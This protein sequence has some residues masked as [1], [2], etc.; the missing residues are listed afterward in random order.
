MAASGLLIS[1]PLPAGAVYDGQSVPGSP[2]VL[3]ILS[4]KESRQSFCSASLISERVVVT[5]AHCVIAS[6]SETRELRFSI[7]ETYVSQP[8]ADVR[9][10]ALDSRVRVLRVVT[11]D[12][13]VN[14]WKPEIGDVRTQVHDIAFMFLAQPLV[15]GYTAQVAT[16]QEVDAATAA[17]QSVTQFGYGLQQMGSQ[18]HTPWMTRM[19][20][21]GIWPSQLGPKSRY[22]M[23]QEGPSALCPGDSGGPWYIDVGGSLKLAAVTV[24]AGG[25]R[26][27]PPYNSMA[28]ATR[29]H[30][31]LDLLDRE[32]ARFLLDEARLQE[33]E[34]L[35]AT[36]LERA[37]SSGTF[38]SPG[39][40]HARGIGV[41]VQIRRV[42]GVWER[43]TGISGWLP[44]G[45]GC[46]SSHPVVPWAV[47]DAAAGSWLRWRYWSSSWETFSPTFQ[48]IL[49][50]TKP[51][52]A[53][54]E[55]SG[56]KV[57]I[58]CT[59]GK[60]TKR[61]TGIAPKCPSGYKRR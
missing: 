47:I 1:M 51:T 35:R 9:V 53:V 40:C 19:P 20:L 34:R 3:T 6:D 37:R 58:V 25:C 13:Y 28:L 14:V 57:T 18:T 21:L 23:A 44:S 49:P 16:E 30:A 10:D 31:Y 60:V 7:E 42:D 24:A 50:P 29:I 46:S 4:S 43:L 27:A 32:W 48:W 45:A 26:S 12:D 2:H 38:A 59:K 39:G 36:A 15:A 54:G 52:S 55:R 17:R 5:A 11:M 33:Q 41:E 56:K 8:G 61:V 22:L